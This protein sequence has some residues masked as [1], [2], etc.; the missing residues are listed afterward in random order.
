MVSSLGLANC[1]LI[2]SD[3]NY[4]SKVVTGDQ[5][6]LTKPRASDLV[7]DCPSLAQ[8]YATAESSNGGWDCNGD[9]RPHSRNEAFFCGLLPPLTVSNFGP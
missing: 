8:F 6:S 7:H 2:A 3:A 5:T 1:N 4:A 9:V